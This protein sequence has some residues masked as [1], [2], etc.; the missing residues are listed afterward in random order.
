MNNT[1]SP[2]LALTSAGWKT[3]VASPVVLPPTVITICFAATAAVARTYAQHKRV[4]TYPTQGERMLT[5]ARAEEA[6]RRMAKGNVR[7]G[8][9]CKGAKEVVE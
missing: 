1:V 9:R 5:K 4:S 8:R 2:M 6:S 7:V 3:V